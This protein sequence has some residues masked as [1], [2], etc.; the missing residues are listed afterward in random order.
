M[1]RIATYNTHEADSLQQLVNRYGAE[2]VDVVKFP[3]AVYEGAI[4]RTAGPAGSNQ[5]DIYDIPFALAD[6]VATQFESLPDL[7]AP[8]SRRVGGCLPRRLDRSTAN[9]RRRGRI[10]LALLVVHLDLP[11]RSGSPA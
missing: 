6:S 11:R 3:A 10:A 1:L 9:R 2:K 5:L 7:G 4:L 8:C